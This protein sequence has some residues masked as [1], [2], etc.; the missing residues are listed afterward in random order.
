MPEPGDNGTTTGGNVD[1]VHPGDNDDAQK[2][3]DKDEDEDGN[4]GSRRQTRSAAKNKQI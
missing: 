4:K 1:P 3:K 2:E